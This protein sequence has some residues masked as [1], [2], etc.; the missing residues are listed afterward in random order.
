M[1]YSASRLETYR[2]CPQKFKF[3]Y[4]DGIKTPS[5]GIEAF[6]GSR[7]HEALEKLYT[8]LKFF[9]EVTLESLLDYY[10]QIWD[11]EWHEEIRIVREELTPENYLAMGEKCIVDYFNRYFPFDQNRTLGIEYRVEFNLDK[12]GK[13]SLLGFV[14]RISRPKDKVIW[15]HD[16][17]AKGFLPTQQDLDEDRQLPFYQMAVKELWPDTEEVEL[18]W[19]YLLFDQEIHSRRT[20]EEL[21]ALRQET[22]D[23]IEEI[24]SATAFPT[25]K[26][27]LCTWCEHQPICPQFR[28]LFETKSLPQNEYMG[29]EGVQLGERLVQL[30]SEDE[31]LKAEIAKVKEALI[32]YSKSKGVEVVFTKGYKVLIRVY[33][34][35]KFPGKKDPGRANLEKLVKAAGKWEEVSF[36][37]VFA[38]SKV[39]EKGGWDQAL[40]EKVKKFGTPGQS[41]WIKAF[42]QN[43]RGW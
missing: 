15:I 21:E 31:K 40:I 34:N 11:K 14:D 12:A 29:E 32:D 18:V 9:R 8:D 1:P 26:S 38:L 4:I 7:V 22:I 24:E 30:Q 20:D 42:P 28:H 6:M 39:L 13:H 25:H 23:L 2:Q 41:P 27:G 43:K 5:E 3:T 33:D 37:D 10:R 36:L 17:K 19:H 35:F 16:Y